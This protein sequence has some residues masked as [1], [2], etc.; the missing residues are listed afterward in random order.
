MFGDEAAGVV[1]EPVVDAGG[2][3][4]TPSEPVSSPAPEPGGPSE[5]TDSLSDLDILNQPDEPAAP[6]VDPPADKPADEPAKPADTPAEPKADD[7]PAVEKT[8]EEKAA[9]EAKAGEQDPADKAVTDLREAISKS[10]AL[11]AALDADP[12]LRNRMFRNARLAVEA[13]G[14]R[15]HFA[16]PA[17]AEMARVDAEDFAEIE[18]D[19]FAGNEQG[20]GNLLKRIFESDMK[21]DDKGEPVRDANGAPIMEGKADHFFYQYRKNE[22]Y[23]A[24]LALAKREGKEAEV[25]EALATI[26]EF[27]GETEAAPGEKKQPV[28]AKDDTSRL[29][30]QERT[31]LAEHDSLKRQQ[32]QADQETHQTYLKSVS[33]EVE[34]GVTDFLLSRVKRLAPALSE[35]LQKKVASDAFKQLN[36]IAAK[37]PL[38]Q[39]LKNNI[40]RLKGDE[41]KGRLKVEAVRFTESRY[42]DV[43]RELVKEYGAP[44]V[45]NNAETRKKLDEQKTRTDVKGGGGA[46]SPTPQDD[47]AMIAEGDKLSREIH[48]RRLSNQELLNIEEILPLLRGKAAAQT[49]ARR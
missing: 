14:Y 8:P 29:T 33:T 9:E 23:P 1:A 6:V 34:T 49:A 45:Q 16:T 11:K 3:S 39:R 20:H 43:L 24:V 36:G 30:P 46:P 42:G 38:F 37:D 15:K 32:A 5:N 19:F 10:P 47:A 12:A 44:V 41:A 2:G 22:F 40:L 7:K 35:Q 25:S 28:A 21:R 18:T 13:E 48:G 31:A 26:Q 4:P 17:M 27:L